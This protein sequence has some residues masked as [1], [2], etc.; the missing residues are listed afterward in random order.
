MAQASSPSARYRPVPCRDRRSQGT[1]ARGYSS[2]RQKRG[3]ISSARSQYVSA[4]CGSPTRTYA[5][6]IFERPITKSR[7]LCARLRPFCSSGSARS[8]FAFAQGLDPFGR[9]RVA[10]ADNGLHLGA[11]SKTLPPTDWDG[12]SANAV[13]HASVSADRTHA[14]DTQVNLSVTALMACSL[15]VYLRSIRRQGQKHA[16]TP[17]SKTPRE[18][19]LALPGFR[20]RYVLF[21]LRFRQ[22]ANFQVPIGV[23]RVDTQA[24]PPAFRKKLGTAASALY[25]T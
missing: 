5:A 16:L 12:G 25:L 1:R 14:R 6:Q 23:A 22:F 11:P 20:Q 19:G 10:W 4:V 18:S 2:A 17:V 7:S 9:V 13:V 3:F 15:T 8:A 21:R 24:N